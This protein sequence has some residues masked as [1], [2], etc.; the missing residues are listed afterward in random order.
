M[1]LSTWHVHGEPDLGTSLTSTV[2]QRSSKAAIQLSLHHVCTV[3]FR[4]DSL[5]W[6]GGARQHEEGA[7]RV[8]A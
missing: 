3:S 6:V 2:L 1:Y 4:A 7:Y 8:S 5:A